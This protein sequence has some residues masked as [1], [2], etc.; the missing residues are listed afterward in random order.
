MGFLI[1]ASVWPFATLIAPELRSCI[2]I[3]KYLL[4]AEQDIV[5][6]GPWSEIT[7][8]H[9][10][11]IYSTGGEWEGVAGGPASPSRFQAHAFSLM[12]KSRM[13]SVCGSTY[14]DCTPVGWHP[15]N[16]GQFQSVVGSF[17][18]S[19]PLMLPPLGTS[20]QQK[21]SLRGQSKGSC[22]YYMTLPDRVC[23]IHRRMNWSNQTLEN[24]L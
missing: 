15:R 13:P 1:H 14:R 18:R 10:S 23:L 19:C 17:W 11:G 20:P 5:L 7:L 3:Y 16:T 21:P 22:V 4:S 12:C 9:S 2:S 24:W 8:R 6:T